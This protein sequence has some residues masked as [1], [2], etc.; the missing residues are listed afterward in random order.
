[1][2]HIQILTGLVLAVA[3]AA[4]AQPAIDL[5]SWRVVDL[6]HPFDAG[7]LYWPTSPSAF[8]LTTLASGMTPGGYFYSSYKLCT[9]EHGGTHL[10]AP[11]HFSKTG[12]NTA[13]LPLRQLIAPAVVIDV[14]RQAAADAAYRVTRADIEAFEA[15][16]GRIAPG[17]IVLARTGWS[18]YWP[19]RKRYLGDDTPGDASKLKF[20]GYGEDAA[21]FLVEQRQVAVL[22]IDTAS[23][24]YG[25]STDFRSAP[26]R[27][28]G[29]RGQPRKPHGARPAAADRRH[30]HRPAHED[31]RRIGRAGAG[32]RAS[33]AS[34]DREPGL[35][36]GFARWPG[37]AAAGSD[38]RGPSPRACSPAAF[39]P[40]RSARPSPA[41]RRPA[42]SHSRCRW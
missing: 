40:G 33:G 32:G 12:V 38:P 26:R 8:E 25:P 19:D 31:R 20:P 5:R 6:T 17:T 3:H 16:H 22:G 34:S 35:A 28:G 27:R 4:S 10:D 41:L 37:R 9:P 36:A 13:D 7:T 18:R 15:A 42:A 21:R 30:G 23:I 24:D 1:M 29:Q 11:V 14:T 39:R 2:R